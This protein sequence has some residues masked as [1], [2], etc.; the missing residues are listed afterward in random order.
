MHEA[1]INAIQ[2]L[3]DSLQDEAFNTAI[4][5]VKKIF[6]KLGEGL[7][8][9][10][11]KIINIDVEAIN[12]D[13][14]VEIASKHRVEGCSEVAAYKTATDDEYFIYLAY[15]KDKELLDE[16]LNNFVVIRCESIARDVEKLFKDE[17]LIIL[18]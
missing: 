12:K 2:P 8:Q 11:A 18:K 9:S 3:L 10:N 13:I 7:K 1:I 17:Q 15:T 16:S 6:T 4:E 14:L 5:S